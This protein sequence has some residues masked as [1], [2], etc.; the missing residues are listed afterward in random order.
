MSVLNESRVS[1]LINAKGAN[2]NFVSGIL[3]LFQKSKL[4][5]EVHCLNASALQTKSLEEWIQKGK[6]FS[7]TGNESLGM[8]AALAADKATGAHTLFLADSHHQITHLIQ[9]FN[10]FKKSLNQSSLLVLN[11]TDKN[12]KTASG[13]LKNAFTRIFTPLNF[14]DHFSGALF[15]KTNG[16][17]TLFANEL[18][19]CNNWLQILDA[20]Q[21]NEISFTEVPIQ[22]EKPL[23][24]GFPAILAGTKLIW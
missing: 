20:I 10:A 1:V 19:S 2:E 23:T 13:K 14:R 21:R 4:D 7:Y 12:K 9:G 8:Q 24:L 11:Q 18:A 3:N 6:F 5:I 22:T 15:A 16:L 17:N